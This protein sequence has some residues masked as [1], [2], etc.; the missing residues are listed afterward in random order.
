MTISEC[1]PKKR[2]ESNAFIE[3]KRNF[4]ASNKSGAKGRVILLK[5]PFGPAQTILGVIAMAE[6]VLLKTSS[7]VNRQI[8]PWPRYRPWK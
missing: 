7:G 5:T 2:K 8:E 1:F 6:K 4:G 3:R